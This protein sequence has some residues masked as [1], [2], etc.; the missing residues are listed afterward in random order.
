MKDFLRHALATLAY[1]GGKV[2]RNAP[3]GFADF[4]PGD[5]TRTPL[6]IVAHIGDLMEWGTV[7]AR[8]E[9]SWNEATP[10]AWDLEVARFFETLRRFDELLAS[11]QPLGCSG[12]RLFQGPIADAFTHVGQLAMLRGLAGERVRAENYFGADVAVGRI[13]AEQTPPKREW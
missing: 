10:Q 7:L 5:K 12:E 6:Q 2:M 8:G 13:G 11:D 9:K 3:V 4:R 1:R